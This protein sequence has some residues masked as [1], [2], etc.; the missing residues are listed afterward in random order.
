MQRL[1]LQTK[2]YTFKTLLLASLQLHLRWTLSQRGL[3]RRSDGMPTSFKSGSPPS[4]VGRAAAATAK[5][6]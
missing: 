6:W 2:R 1:Q 4:P 3:P 5:A